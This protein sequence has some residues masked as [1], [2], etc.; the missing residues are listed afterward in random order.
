MRKREKEPTTN[1]FGIRREP[2]RPR[3]K[4]ETDLRKGG[5]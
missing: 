2:Q 1:F 4:S 5:L 3:N